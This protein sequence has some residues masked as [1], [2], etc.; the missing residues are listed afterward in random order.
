MGVL[1]NAPPFDEQMRHLASFMHLSPRQPHN[2]IYPECDL[3]LRSLGMG[4]VGLPGD[5]SSPSRFLR[6]VF[7]KSHARNVD[8]VTDFLK[9]LDTVTQVPGCNGEMATLYSSCC[10]TENGIY[11]YATCHSRRLYG[12]DMNRVDLNAAEL[13]RYP[14]KTQEDLDLQN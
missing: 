7:T 11:C 13:M 9:I 2:H 1:T 14:L 4:A 6:A 12:I 10:D 5:L 3:P 8:T